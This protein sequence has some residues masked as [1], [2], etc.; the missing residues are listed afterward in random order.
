MQK[1]IE[2]EL[3]EVWFLSIENL[4][5]DGAFHG[6]GTLFRNGLSSF[7]L[8][9]IHGLAVFLELPDAAYGVLAS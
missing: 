2:E 7:R 1:L 5:D 3:A 8:R 4:L 6:P 9:M